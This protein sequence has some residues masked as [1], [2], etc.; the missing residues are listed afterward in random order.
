MEILNKSQCF[1]NSQEWFVE[2]ELRK[3]LGEME[4]KESNM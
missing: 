2:T 4:Q 1:A 3:T